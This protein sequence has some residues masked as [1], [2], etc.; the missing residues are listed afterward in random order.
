VQRMLT[1][2]Y[3]GFTWEQLRSFQKPSYLRLLGMTEKGRQYLNQQKKNIAL[4]LVSR[5]ADLTATMGKLD[6]HASSMYLLG[7]GAADLK[8]EFTTPPRYF[9]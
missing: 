1:H 5:A 9:G 4:P 2:I 7:M 3:T 8:K 6:I